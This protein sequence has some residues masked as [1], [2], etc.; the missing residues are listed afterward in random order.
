[1]TPPNLVSGTWLT[2]VWG[3][4]ATAYVYCNGALTLYK[5]LFND[6]SSGGVQVFAGG[7]SGEWTEVSVTVK[8]GESLLA[9]TSASL[10][11]YWEA[12]Q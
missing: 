3:Q 12:A 11:S 1:L 2:N 6:R 10:S 7:I 8:S 9:T 4:D 5:R